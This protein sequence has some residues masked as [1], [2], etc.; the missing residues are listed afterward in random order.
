VNAQ[1]RFVA[2][3]SQLHFDYATSILLGGELL[4][5][6]GVHAVVA[7]NWDSLLLQ[8]LLSRDD[9]VLFDAD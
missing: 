9:L 3:A 8:K 4:L 1:N 6:R 7:S 5:D 2:V